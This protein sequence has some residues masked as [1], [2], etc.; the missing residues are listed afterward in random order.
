MICHTCTWPFKQA[1]WSGVLPSLF[2][3]A[4]SCKAGSQ[5]KQLAILTQRVIQAIHVL[6]QPSTSI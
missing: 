4:A 3:G 1:K 5:Q 6:L 2:A